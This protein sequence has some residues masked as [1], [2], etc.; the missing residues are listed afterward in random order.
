MRSAQIFAFQN[1]RGK[2]LTNLEVLKAYLMLQVYMHSDT[3]ERSEED[4]EYIESNFATVYRQIGKIRSLKEDDV[5]LYLWRAIGPKG[6]NS[7]NTLSEIKKEIHDS[8]DRLKWIKNFSGKIACAFLFVENIE[9]S[10]D[11]WIRNLH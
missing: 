8:G 5:L 9:S 2:K 7:E 11:Q 10:N 1:D 3:R 4:I 6:L